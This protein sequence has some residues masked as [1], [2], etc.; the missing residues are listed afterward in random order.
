MPE[1]LMAAIQVHQYGG[2]EQ[3]RLEQVA[4]PEP[5]VGEVLI[6][7][8]AA[9]VLPAEWKVRQGFF[10]AFRPSTFPYIPGSAVAGVVEALGPGVTT[11]QV[12]QRVLGRS[13]NGVYAEYTTTA[14]APPALG[15]NTFSLLAEIPEGLS[16]EEAATV[17]GGA[18]TAWAAL[19]HDAALQASQ[20]VLIHGGAGGVGSYAVQFARWK[21]A[22]VIATASAANLDFVRSLGAE[23]VIDYATTAFEQVA[24][25]MDVVLDTIGGETL[26]RSPQTLKRGGVLV[27]LLENSPDELAAQY[28]VRAMKNTVAP[29]N[30]DLRAIGRLLASGHIKATIGQVFP[31]R[32]AARAQELSQGGHGRGRIVLR[33]PE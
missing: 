19:F 7:V 14:V 12:G 17:S 20:R 30:D 6:R 11:F 26:R 3:L 31:L 15:A 25:D 27:S 1:R 4:R 22:R 33:I 28:G 16:F 9:G 23:T 18:T 29:T 13:V 32:E 24:R 21:G 2:P 10:R 5:Q 8:H